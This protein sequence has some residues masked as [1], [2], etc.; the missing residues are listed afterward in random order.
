M[1]R[2][3]QQRYAN[4]Q[5]NVNPTTFLEGF[6]GSTTLG[7]LCSLIYSI[8]SANRYSNVRG[9]NSFLLSSYLVSDH[10]PPPTSAELE[11]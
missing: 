5:F 1:D 8:H 6:G 11:F 2:P 10:P 3:P 7:E 4:E 9:S